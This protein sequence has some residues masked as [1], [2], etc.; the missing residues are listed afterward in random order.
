MFSFTSPLQW[1]NFRDIQMARNL[2]WLHN[3][4]Y[5]GAKKII[6]WCS[7]AAFNLRYTYS[8]VCAGLRITTLC[9]DNERLRRRTIG[10]TRS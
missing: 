1:N 2:I 9:S 8:V 10:T 5:G 7:A 6:T 3:T 4:Y